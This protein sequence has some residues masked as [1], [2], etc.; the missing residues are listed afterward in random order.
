MTP[1]IRKQLKRGQAIKPHISYMKIEGNLGCW[2]SD[3]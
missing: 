2:R 1:A 3:Q